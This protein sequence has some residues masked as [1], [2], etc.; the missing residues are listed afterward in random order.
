LNCRY[1]RNFFMSLFSFSSIFVGIGGI[2]VV[3]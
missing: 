1:S 2:V 3:K